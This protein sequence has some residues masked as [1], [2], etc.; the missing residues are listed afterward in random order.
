MQFFCK[1][2]AAT[3][4]SSKPPKTL[5]SHSNMDANDKDIWD[6]SYTEEYFGLHN[7]THTWKY[8]T[9]TEYQQL[10]KHMGHVLPTIA[11]TTIKPDK[12]GRPQQ[13]KC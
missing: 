12:Y 6:K 7:D 2:S 5:N 4:A 9:K 3:L 1:V 11:L 13:A 8:I 10:K